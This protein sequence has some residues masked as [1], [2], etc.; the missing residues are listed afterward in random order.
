MRLDILMVD[1][2]LAK[3]RARAQELIKGGKV[4]ITG[5]KNLKPSLDVAE[6]V[7]I[8]MS[9]DDHPYVSRAAFK[10][11]AIIDATGFVFRDKVVL[12]IGASTGGFTQVALEEGAKHIYAIDVGHGQLD[13]AFKE[14]AQVTSLEKTDGRNLLPSMVR[15]TPDVVL[16]DVSFISCTKILP[17]MILSFPSINDVLVLVKPQFELTPDDIGHGGIVRD[18]Q[19]CYDALEKVKQ[20]LIDLGFEVPTFI[21]SP[22][23]NSKS[24]QEFVIHARRPIE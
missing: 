15:R 24:N 23:N 4:K 14:D 18:K 5:M 22:L 2:K 9:E 20:C 1:K 3:S 13:A 12:D 16:C 19:R 6:D 7:I 10:L 21:K 8:T 17:H 11:K